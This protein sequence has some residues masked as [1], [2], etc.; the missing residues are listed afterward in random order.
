MGRSLLVLGICGVMALAALDTGAGAATADSP[1]V[2]SAPPIVAGSSIQNT[3]LTAA[4]GSWSGT[5]PISYTY[6]WRICDAQGADCSN[7]QGATRQTHVVSAGAVGRTLRVQVTA[8]NSV[9]SASAASNP[10][11]VIAEATRPAATRQP[12]VTGPLQVGATLT[13]G[14]GLWSGS[15]PLGFSFAWQRCRGSVCRFIAQ[16]THQTYV[17]TAADVG[18]RLRARVTARNAVGLGTVFSNLTRAK[19]TVPGTGPVNLGLP[20]ISGKLEEGQRV[21]VNTGAWR[22]QSTLSF[23]YAWLRCDANGANC[24]PLPSQ[25]AASYTLTSADVNRA[26]RAQVTAINSSGSSTTT[27]STTGLV[28][29]RVSHLIRL[30]TGTYSVP[31]DD[32]S[33]PQRLIISSVSFTPTRLRSRAPFTARIRVTDT[34]GYAVR[35]ALVYVIGLPYGR[36]AGAP[37]VRTNT[38]GYAT[39]RLRPTEQLPL[40][41]GSSLVM[42]VRARSETG[43]L[44]AGVSTR[45]LVQIL[46]SR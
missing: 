24:T 7:I 8:S 20:S 10:T 12:N 1:P 14:A 26:M 23:R 5:S 21:A 27:S 38:A 17:A 4:T 37:E 29:K 31:A 3:T 45:R 35:N 16:A 32:V 18:M 33:L 39:L 36:L 43:N 11:A 9:G 25:T 30:S 44:L 2:M 22:S 13:V 46:A 19:I 15:S 42:F 6:Q 34:R 40:G 28:A 41:R